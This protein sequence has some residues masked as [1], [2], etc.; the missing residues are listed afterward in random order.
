MNF[1]S[2]LYSRFTRWG[3]WY[4][5]C[6]RT[7]TFCTQCC[8]A[9]K[10]GCYKGWLMLFDFM[11]CDLFIM[12]QFVYHHILSITGITC[13]MFKCLNMITYSLPSV[14]FYC[15]SEIWNINNMWQMLSNSNFDFAWSNFSDYKS[16]NHYCYW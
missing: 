3:N 16:D 5:C 2:C 9:K 8:W 13:G 4:F 10:K 11:I 14:G 7:E 1:F 15:C 6:Q 12:A